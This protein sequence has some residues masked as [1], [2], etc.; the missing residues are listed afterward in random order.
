LQ[1]LQVPSH[2]I[3]HNEKIYGVKIANTARTKGGNIRNEIFISLEQTARA[4]NLQICIQAHL[5]LETFSK[6]KEG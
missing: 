2:T 5:N 1:W 3:A 6:G 4:R